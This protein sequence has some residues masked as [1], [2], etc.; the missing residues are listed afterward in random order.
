[1]VL[2]RNEFAAQIWWRYYECD[3]HDIINVDETA[4]YYEMPPGKIWYEK[5]KSSQVDKKQKHS[6][7][8][9]AVLTCRADGMWKASYFVY[10]PRHPVPGG[11]SN[12]NELSTYPEGHYY[13][14]Q[15]SAWMDGRLWDSYLRC[16]RHTLWGQVSF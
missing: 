7:R 12:M 16:C 2:L 9:N 3:L 13:D 1:M 11:I 14:D 10:C 5:G 15:E 4:V 6:D 8:L